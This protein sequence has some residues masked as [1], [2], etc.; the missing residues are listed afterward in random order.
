MIPDSIEFGLE[1]RLRSTLWQDGSWVSSDLT[2]K[3]EMAKKN[4]RIKEMRFCFIIIQE[5]SGYS[6]S[7]TFLSF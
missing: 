1:Q 4:W 6:L 5:E 3:D 2:A 7:R